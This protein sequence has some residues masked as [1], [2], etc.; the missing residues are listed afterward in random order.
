MGFAQNGLPF[1]VLLSGAW[2]T[3]GADMDFQNK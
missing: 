2:L 3:G 1:A